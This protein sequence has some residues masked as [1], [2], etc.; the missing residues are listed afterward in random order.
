MTWISHLGAILCVGMIA[1]GQVL[2][3][4]V[5]MSI[6]GSGTVLDRQV[7]LLGGTAMAIYGL[8][9]LFWIALLR[10]APLGRLYPYMALSFVFVTFA[11][12]AIFHEAV[13][14][15]HI[16]GLAMIVGGLILIAAF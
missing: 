11:S 7:I 9:T 6:N 13:T 16:A 4:L 2:F 3:K 15:G 8:A 12:S 1:T 5:A 14:P 10:E